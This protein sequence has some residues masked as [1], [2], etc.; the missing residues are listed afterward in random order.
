MLFDEVTIEFFFLLK[1]GENATPV[2]TML[3]PKYVDQQHVT[4]NYLEKNIQE[5]L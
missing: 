5:K 1:N 4:L 3:L 2:N